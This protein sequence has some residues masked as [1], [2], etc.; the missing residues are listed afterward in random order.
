L[1]ERFRGLQPSDKDGVW[2]RWSDSASTWTLVGA[3]SDST[4][5]RF[6]V[7][8]EQAVKK[9]SRGTTWQDFL[10]V[11]REEPHTFKREFFLL[12]YSEPDEPESGILRVCEAAADYCEQ[13]IPE[14]ADNARFEEMVKNILYAPIPQAVV[15]H[16]EPPAPPIESPRPTPKSDSSVKPVGVGN[17]ETVG[18][19]V[20][21]FRED[22]RLTVEEL[23]EQAGLDATT[24]GR[25]IRGEMKA[26]LRSIGAYERVFSKILERKIVISNTPSE[27]LPNA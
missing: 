10:N 2:A 18:Q 6:E 20:N 8:S 9:T 5:R 3:P 24:V 4:L 7:L 12:G 27:R 17:M 1:C 11:L 23:A 13:F 26:S 16:P 21:R 25:H 15:H 19:Q 22:C 14:D